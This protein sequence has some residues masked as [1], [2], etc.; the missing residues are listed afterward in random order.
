MARKVKGQPFCGWPEIQRNALSD[1][2]AEVVCPS[3]AFR[4]SEGCRSA[5]AEPGDSPVAEAVQPGESLVAA[6]VPGDSHAAEVAQQDEPAE[7]ESYATARAP[8]DTAEEAVAVASPAVAPVVRVSSAEFQA[9]ETAVV[10]VPAEVQAHGSA[11]PVGLGAV[12]EDGYS[13][14]AFPGIAGAAV[15][16][17]ADSRRVDE[18]PVAPDGHFPA[19][20]YAFLAGQAGYQAHPG[21]AHSGSAGRVHCY[22]GHCY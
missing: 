12:P 18:E 10:A 15:P 5:E 21:V 22:K 9:G 20:H 4:F 7:A 1:L 17:M 11:A 3:Q 16:V 19:E 6:E 14:A 8:D 13:Q 2:G